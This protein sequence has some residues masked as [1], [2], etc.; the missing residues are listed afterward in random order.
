MIW[1]VYMVDFNNRDIKV[2]NIFNHSRFNDS[3]K[4]LKK[5]KLPKEEFADRL[6]RELMYYFG[7]KYEYETVIT[8]FPPHITLKELDDAI[9]ERDHRIKVYGECRGSINICPES[10][11]KVDIYQQVMLNWDVFVDYVWEVKK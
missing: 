9:E 11:I 7:S 5:A 2:F 3:V 6:N 4:K 1:N 8:T 10:G